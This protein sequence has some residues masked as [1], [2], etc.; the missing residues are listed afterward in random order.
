MIKYSLI[1]GCYS[2]GAVMMRWKNELVNEEVD[3][4]AVDCTVNS[5]NNF[6]KGR[7]LT[8]KYELNAEGYY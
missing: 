5:F 6:A 2:F 3:C 7:R 8:G 4:I 1:S